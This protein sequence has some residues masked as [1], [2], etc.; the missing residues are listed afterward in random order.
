MKN[1]DR[2][3]K[4]NILIAVFSGRESAELGVKEL[5]DSHYTKDEIN[6]I[7]SEE[8]KVNLFAEINHVALLSENS[9]EMIFDGM[10]TGG[11]AG[12]VL[13][14]IAAFIAAVGSNLIIPGLGL[15]ALGPMVAGL[16]GAGAGSIA[17]GLIGALIAYDVPE[18]KANLFN[19]ELKKGKILIGVHP[20]NFGDI[21]KFQNAWKKIGAEKIFSNAY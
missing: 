17:G 8:T 12:G 4:R 16:V 13:V 11:T 19:E 3:K 7:M 9:S 14:G 6:I 5:M 15:V 21:D 1:S 2:Q 18:N 10:K 20:R